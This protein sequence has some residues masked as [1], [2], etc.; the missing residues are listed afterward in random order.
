VGSRAPGLDAYADNPKI[1][2]GDTPLEDM[3]GDRAKV[4]AAMIEAGES[5]DPPKRL[6]LGSDAYRLVHAALSDRLAAFE[7]QEDVA[8][9]TDVDDFHSAV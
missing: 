1:A 5:D 2:R 8:R 3:P 6:L 9:S 7:A 4:V